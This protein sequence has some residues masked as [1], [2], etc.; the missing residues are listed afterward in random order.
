MFQFR[1]VYQTH[2]YIWKVL[3]LNSLHVPI[4]IKQIRSPVSKEWIEEKE[5]ALFITV[6]GLPKY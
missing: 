6:V 4:F 1:G 2:D 5:V 3:I